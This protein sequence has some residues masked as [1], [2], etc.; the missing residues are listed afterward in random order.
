MKAYDIREVPLSQRR[1]LL[2]QALESAESDHV[3]FS[4]TLDAPPRDMVAAACK[5]GLEGIIGK[6]K[7]GAY[8]SRRSSDWIKLKCGHRQEFVVGGYTDPK[9]SRA[10]IGSLLVGAYDDKGALQYAGSVGSGFNDASL[11]D[12]TKKLAKQAAD[13]SPFAAGKAIDKKAHWVKPE[14]VA[15]VSYAEWTKSGSLR[16]P[17]FQGLRADKKARG[18]TRE[19]PEHPETEAEAPAAAAKPRR[20]PGASGPGTQSPIGDVES[21]LPATL[22]VTNPDRVIDSASGTTKIGL[23]RYYALVAPLMVE[24]LKGRPV[25]LVR[26]PS[27]V[28]GDQ[29]TLST[30][31]ARLDVGNAP[32]DGYDKAAVA[33]AKPMKAP[34]FSPRGD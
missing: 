5:L 10:G 24:H 20:K 29:W 15:E 27:G 4:A 33:L 21:K 13:A 34:G 26:A 3:R 1:E 18:I 25:S 16:H 23:V 22:K 28:G 12:I 14:L 19:T 8:V 30:V 2:R 9:G 7:D 11:R 32:W 31:H 6:R 17:V